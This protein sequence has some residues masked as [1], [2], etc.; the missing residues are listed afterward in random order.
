MLLVHN[1]SC[2]ISEVFVLLKLGLLLHLL[3][4]LKF[5]P[6]FYR[7]TVS[8]YRG[9]KILHGMIQFSDIMLKQN[10]YKG[11]YDLNAYNLIFCDTLVLLMKAQNSTA[12]S[13]QKKL[14]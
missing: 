8:S 7:L 9:L 6:S 2:R 11:L 1:E 4:I 12:W 5:S 10:C 3:Q 14:E 13:N